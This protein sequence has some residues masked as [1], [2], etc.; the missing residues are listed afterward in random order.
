[1]TREESRYTIRGLGDR[2][3]TDTIRCLSETH[4]TVTDFR[5]DMAS[6]EDV[7]LKLTGHSIRD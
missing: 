1:M 6:L 7:F 3:I 5:T 2:F 4:V